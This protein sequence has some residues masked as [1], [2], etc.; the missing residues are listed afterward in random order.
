MFDLFRSRD[1]A[2]RILLTALLSLVALS[3]VAL[4]DTE[5]RRVGSDSRR[6]TPSSP[7]SAR[8]KVTVHDVQMAVRAA[9][10]NREMPPGM[11]A[12]YVPQM[13]EQMITEKAL[14]YQANRMGLA[15]DRGRDGQGH[16]RADAAT[17]PQ[18]P[19][20]SGRKPTPRRWRS[21][22]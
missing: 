6:T 8:H 13:I 3:M 1:K 2:V 7:T 20:S 19:V 9:T 5:V 10:R 4:P 14:I 22:T 16:P 18:W 11:M 17:F 21:R 12:H 15:G